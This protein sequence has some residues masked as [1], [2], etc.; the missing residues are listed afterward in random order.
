MGGAAG[1]AIVNF[2]RRN[3]GESGQ[4]REQQGCGEEE[5]GAIR[6][7]IADETHE[8][9]GQHPS[10]GRKTLIAPKPLA[11]LGLANQSKTNRSDGRP[12]EPSGHPLQ[13]E[14]HQNQGKTRPNC[15]NDC[16]GCDHHGAE[17]DGGPLGSY[18]IEQFSARDLAHE[19]S[20]ATSRQDETDILECPALVREKERDIGAKAGQRCGD[21][22]INSV[23]SVHAGGRGPPVNR[24]R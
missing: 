6:Q 17:R 16:A 5:D 21:E 10:H 19:A 12:E 11:K 22:E 9:G 15:N 24:I 20:E 18:R 14:G 3:P 7:I 8:A 4:Q 13:Q 1:A 2:G 23:E